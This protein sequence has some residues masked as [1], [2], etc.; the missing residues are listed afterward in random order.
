MDI[1]SIILS[2]GKGSRMHSSTAK[3]LHTICGKPMIE[4]V[5]ESTKVAGIK[6]NIIVIPENNEDFK[7][8]TKKYEAIIQH[9]PLGTGMLLK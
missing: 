2:A 6:K 4:W 3:P 9:K 5:I 7:E 1:C 8:I